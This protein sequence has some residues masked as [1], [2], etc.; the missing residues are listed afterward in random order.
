MQQC[1]IP[2]YHIFIL[3]ST[4]YSDNTD[5]K[6]TQSG[7]GGASR[8]RKSSTSS[9]NNNPNTPL[10]KQ[11]AAP[12]NFQGEWIPDPKTEQDLKTNKANFGGKSATM[13]SGR[14]SHSPAASSLSSH[15]PSAP[16]PR[17]H[18]PPELQYANIDHGRSFMNDPRNRVLPGSGP[19]S[20]SASLP[21]RDPPT[22][23]AAI[24]TR[25]ER[26][27]YNYKTSM[28]G[29]GPGL[30]SSSKLV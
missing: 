27:S 1:P 20:Q 12:K 23:Y 3:F 28:G 19:S 15:E 18:K 9:S 8:S 30:V 7:S 26:T 25:T 22:T 13:D 4:F 14:S 17:P 2:T 10:N 29:G 5:G 16:P 6:L 24:V 21:S 11:Q